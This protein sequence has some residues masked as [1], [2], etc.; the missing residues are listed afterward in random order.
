MQ[1]RR[2]NDMFHLEADLVSILA[3]QV[4]AKKVFCGM[5]VDY[6]RNTCVFLQYVAIQWNK[7]DQPGVYR[8]CVAA[9]VFCEASLRCS[10]ADSIVRGD[11]FG[12]QPDLM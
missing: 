2:V 5:P 4:V 1:K 11:A 7:L 9:C 12:E 8:F 10:I 3:W 6:R